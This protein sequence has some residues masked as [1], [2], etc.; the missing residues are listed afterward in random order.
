M[1]KIK[2]LLGASALLFASSSN[3]VVIQVDYTGSVTDLGDLLAGDGVALYDNVSGSFTY[4]SD[5]APT[6]SLLDFSVSLGSSFTATMDAT[7]SSWFRVYNDIYS[8]PGDGFNVG[9]GNVTGS[10]LNG[11]TANSMQF[12]VW[13]YNSLGQLWDDSLLP[14]MTD[15][16]NITLADIN[17][18]D[19]RWMDFGLDTDDHWED[20][21]RWDVDS[22]TVSAASVSVPEPSI[23]ALFGAGLVGLGFARRRKSCQA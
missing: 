11:H 13:R 12:G 9:T 19:W 8:N 2:I 18:A 20:Q 5:L 22:F 6:D 14:D 23:I 15:W 1:D 21:I 10:T 4:D 17:L 16:A 3:A 7:G